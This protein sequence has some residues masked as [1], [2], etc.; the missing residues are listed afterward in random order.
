MT[1]QITHEDGRQIVTR[2]TLRRI[3]RGD[4]ERCYC[5][6]DARIQWDAGRCPQHKIDTAQ[7]ADLVRADA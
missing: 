1:T 3:L 2:D 7:D 5:A 6:P 4:G